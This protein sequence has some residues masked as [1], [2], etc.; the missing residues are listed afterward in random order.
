MHNRG[1]LKND[2]P[3]KNAR[4]KKTRNPGYIPGDHWVQCD[5]CGCACRSSDSMRTWDN[6]VVCPDDWEPRHEQ[7]FVRS[8]E[9]RQ[10]PVGNVR[11][12][13]ADTFV[14]TSGLM[15]PSS[16]I[17]PPTFPPDPDFT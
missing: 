13:T 1:K 8:R 9:D 3:R 16:S 4:N 11:P 2:V 10:T 15:P 5:I 12:E 17:P 6:L 7:D 14:D